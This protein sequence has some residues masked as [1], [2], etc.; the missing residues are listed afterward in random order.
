MPCWDH[1]AEK[2]RHQAGFRVV[3]PWATMNGG[4]N[5]SKPPPVG[6]RPPESCPEDIS[7]AFNQS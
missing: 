3:A 2:A 6:L 5:P 1:N 4:A 7:V